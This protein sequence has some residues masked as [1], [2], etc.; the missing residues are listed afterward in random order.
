MDF[1]LNKA[2]NKQATAKL[3]AGEGARARELMAQVRHPGST[4]A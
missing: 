1:A 3:R 2:F 4:D